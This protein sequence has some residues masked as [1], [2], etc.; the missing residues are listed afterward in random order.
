MNRFNEHRLKETAKQNCL[1]ESDFKWT[2]LNETSEVFRKKEKKNNWLKSGTE[3]DWFIFTWIISVRRSARGT[4]TMD[5]RGRRPKN[6]D[7]RSWKNGKS[8]LDEWIEFFHI[9]YWKCGQNEIHINPNFS[10]L[11]QDVDSAA[12]PTIHVSLT[13]MTWRGFC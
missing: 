2:S 4:C 5:R 9:N 10:C 11:C 1:S 6:S 8:R 7:I 13:W 12:A 3:W